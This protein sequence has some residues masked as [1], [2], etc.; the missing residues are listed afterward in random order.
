MG[1]VCVLNVNGH[2]EKMVSGSP[3][4]CFDE[5]EA[6]ELLVIVNID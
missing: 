5:A 1:F 6:F 4:R 2:V 3:F